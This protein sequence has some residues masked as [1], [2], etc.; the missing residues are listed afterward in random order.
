M[1]TT[2]SLAR[3]AMT[4]PRKGWNHLQEQGHQSSFAVIEATYRKQQTFCHAQQILHYAQ[5]AFTA[6]QNQTDMPCS[7]MIY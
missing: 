4:N 1:P 6:G 2:A 7:L 3:F 5:A